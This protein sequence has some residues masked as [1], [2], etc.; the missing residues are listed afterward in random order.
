MN[1]MVS[2]IRRDFAKA[3]LVGYAIFRSVEE[4]MQL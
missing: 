3:V 2:L 1:D 4:L